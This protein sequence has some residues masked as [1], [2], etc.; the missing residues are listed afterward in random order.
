MIKKFYIRLEQM[1]TRLYFLKR[2]R[3]IQKR[4]FALI[5]NIKKQTI[6]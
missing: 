4:V 1:K 5:S 6:S 2:N 3:R